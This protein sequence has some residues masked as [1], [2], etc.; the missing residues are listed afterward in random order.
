[1]KDYVRVSI[2]LF[3]PRYD[4][5]FEVNIAEQLTIQALAKAYA[6]G[7]DRVKEQVRKTGDFGDVA[8]Q[9]KSVNPPPVVGSPLTLSSIVSAMKEINALEGTDSTTQ[10]LDMLVA[11][12]MRTQSDDELRYLVRSFANT[13]LRIGLS[14]KSVENCIMRYFE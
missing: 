13:G 4:E 12:F 6:T 3:A 1:M 11:L 7:V 10:K 5:S 14:S 8:I 2:G 9:L